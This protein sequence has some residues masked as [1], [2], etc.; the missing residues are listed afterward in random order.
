MDRILKLYINYKGVVNNFLSLSILN[1]INLIIPLVTMPY[2][3][4]ILG[5]QLYGEIIYIQSILS[6]GTL[7]VS[8]GINTSGTRL[9]SLSRENTVKLNSIFSHIIYLRIF[10]FSL[11]ALVLTLILTCTDVVSNEMYWVYLIS[12]SLPLGEVLFPLWYFQGV[13]RMHLITIAF[14]LSKLLFLFGVF[15][16]IKGKEDYILFP[17]LNSLS[18]LLMGFVSLFYI[19]KKDGLKFVKLSWIQIYKILK[20]SLALFLSNISLHLFTLSNKVIIGGFVGFNEVSAYEVTEKMVNLFKKPQMILSQAIFPKTSRGVKKTSLKKI[21]LISFLIGILLFASLALMS[22][23]LMTIFGGEDLIEYSHYLIVLGITIP[24]VYYS[25]FAITHGLIARGHDKFWFYII[26]SAAL[27]YLFALIIFQITDAFSV[28]LLLW[29]VVFVEFYILI[30]A[31]I[32]TRK[33]GIL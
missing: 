17:A 13:E 24:I 6:Y 30:L 15:I 21:A 19:L 18:L 31:S 29:L 2:L 3:I 1:G 5:T 10:L 12:M 28:N 27:I 8:F 26:S 22:E 9:V 7:L 25:Q 20:S 32:R 16:L 14:A 33:L 23:K 4:K 11:T